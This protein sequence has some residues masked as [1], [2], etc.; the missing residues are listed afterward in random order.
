MLHGIQP[1]T[2]DIDLAGLNTYMGT[3]WLAA[4]RSGEELALLVGDRVQAQAWREL[5]DRGSAA[6]DEALFTGEYYRQI[7]EDGDPH[8][9]QWETGCLSD[10]LIGQWWAHV[11]DLGYLLPVEHVRTALASVVRHNLRVGFEGFEHPYRVF[12]D[13]DETGLLMCTWPT[14][15]RPEVPTR[16][17]D[18]VWTGIEYQVAAHCEMEGLVAESRAI[19]DGVWRRYDGRRRNPFNE[20]EC[21][22]H[23]VRALS[24]WSVLE[25]RT[26][27][28]WDARTRTLTLRSPA[29]GQAWPLV[30]DD[31]WGQV[32]AAAD[33]A[34]TLRC[35][36]GT[37]AID[38]VRVD[39]DDEREVSVRLG[40]GESAP[41]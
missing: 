7:L 4:L 15:G 35:D 39:R 30:L 10:Q 31:G 5:F 34:L 40:A 33:G 12:A 21:G 23:Y 36:H 37:F 16:Y 13:G 3:L 32:Q 1:S 14:G 28:R 26:G 9:F 17:C 18:E 38:R 29:S 8:E 6:Y 24:G 11:L 2:H 41:L 25:A 27:Q 22:D 19:L 20:I